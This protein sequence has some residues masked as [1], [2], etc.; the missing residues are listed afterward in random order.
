MVPPGIFFLLVM[1][2]SE[3]WPHVI[4]KQCNSG[5]REEIIQQHL[6]V[7]PNNQNYEYID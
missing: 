3:N 6:I 4:T 7:D 5:K 1:N 2:L